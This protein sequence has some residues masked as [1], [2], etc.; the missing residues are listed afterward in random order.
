MRRPAVH[1][2]P[3]IAMLGMVMMLAGAGWPLS[4]AAATTIV[5]YTS[6]SASSGGNAA[7]SGE[8]I[9]GETSNEVRIYTQVNG[10]VVQ[11]YH[12]TSSEPLEH[13]SSYTNGDVQTSQSASAGATTETKTGQD[14]GGTTTSMPI[15]MEASVSGSQGGSGTSSASTTDEAIATMTEALVVTPQGNVFNNIFT[16]ITNTITRIFAYVFN[17]F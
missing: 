15:I 17:L 9:E 12:A 3:Y 1:F 16:S 14:E 6:S 2:L 7:D 11:D 10:K 13:E 5:N 8:V 4:A